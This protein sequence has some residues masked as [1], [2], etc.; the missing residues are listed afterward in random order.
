MWI[1]YSLEAAIIGKKSLIFGTP[2]FLGTP[3]LYE[4][5]RIS[6]D[7]LI[8][9]EVASKSKVKEYILNYIAKYTLPVCVNP[10]GYEYYKKKYPNKIESLLDNSK[11]AQDF[12]SIIKSDFQNQ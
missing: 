12:I 8:K 6:F 1:D 3:N 4:Y 9:K 2:W 10:S 7:N 11:F 5:N